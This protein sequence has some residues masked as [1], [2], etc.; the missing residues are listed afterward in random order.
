MSGEERVEREV[1][2]RCSDLNSLRERLQSAEAERVSAAALEDNLIFDRAG[3]LQQ[4]GC[5]LRL[6]FDVNGA[7]LTYKGPAS[8]E[9]GVKVREERETAVEDADELRAVLEN[10]GYEAVHRYQ[11][12]REE[13]RVGGVIACLDRTPIG[14]FVEF[15]GDAAAKL[16]QRF[17]F[18]PEA[19]ERRSYIG[20]Y[21]DHRRSNP[22]AP[23]EMIFS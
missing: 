1:K 8:F 16:A 18:D 12:Y 23:E 20:L 9:E 7:R 11:K 2:F 19:A 3:E 13:W 22:S 14:D 5:L 6:R 4:R 21:Q 10:L 15:E 17:G